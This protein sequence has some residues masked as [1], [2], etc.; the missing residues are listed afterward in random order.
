[1]RKVLADM[2]VPPALR[3]WATRIAICVAIAVAVAYVPWRVAGGGE[4]AD[5]LRGQLAHLRDEARALD[6]ENARME[7]EIHALRTDPRAI[8][9]H[10]RDELGMVYPGELVLR[11]ETDPPSATN[12]V[13]REAP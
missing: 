8:E 2:H 11:I 4:Q 13:P 9:D 12:P 3:R 10:A 1:V 7:R 6:A 5:K